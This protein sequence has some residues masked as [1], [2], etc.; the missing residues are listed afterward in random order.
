MSEDGRFHVLELNPNPYL[1]SQALV[2][3]MASIG[4]SH[5]QLVVD[6]ALAAIARGGCVVPDGAI[7]IPVGVSRA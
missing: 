4:R 6:I 3:G 7:R 1:N 5:E 2:N